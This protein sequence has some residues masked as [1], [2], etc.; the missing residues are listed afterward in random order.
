[1]GNLAAGTEMTLVVLGRLFKAPDRLETPALEG[2]ALGLGLGLVAGPVVLPGLVNEIPDP[3]LA[4]RCAGSCLGL[5]SDFFGELL[6]EILEPSLA[7]RVAGKLPCCLGLA[8]TTL[9]GVLA[10]LWGLLFK[11]LRCLGLVPEIS[12]LVLALLGPGLLGGVVP[13][14][15]GCLRPDP[16]GLTAPPGLAPGP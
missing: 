11:A 9:G 10:N 12:G 8:G 15:F 4:W 2:L 3:S 16:N 6:N 13:L 1:M 5:S 14:G 7:W